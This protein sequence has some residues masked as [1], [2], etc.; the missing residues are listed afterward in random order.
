MTDIKAYEPL[1]RAWYV[2]SLLG[3]GAFGKV[4]KIRRE[5]FGKAYYSAVKIISIPHNEGEIRQM[6]SEG[7]DYASMQKFLYA[8]VTDIASEVDLMRQF[9]GTSNIVSLEDH[10]IINKAA[11]P[12]SRIPIGTHILPVRHLIYLIHII[13]VYRA[14][15]ANDPAAVVGTAFSEIPQDLIG[16]HAKAQ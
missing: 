14:E 3:E 10:Q 11:L 16:Y 8:F 9:R 15:V 4:Y 13:M 7:L 6:R 12:Q 1:W 5:E 2:D